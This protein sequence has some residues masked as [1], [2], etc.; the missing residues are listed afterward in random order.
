MT[1]KLFSRVVVEELAIVTGRRASAPVIW[2]QKYTYLKGI[3]ESIYEDTR[4]CIQLN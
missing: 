2:I 4:D 3:N 1:L